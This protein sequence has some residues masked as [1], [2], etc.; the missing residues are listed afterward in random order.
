MWGFLNLSVNSCIQWQMPH[1]C[2]V[3][4]H[5]HPLP[6][7]HLLFPSRCVLVRPCVVL[8]Q[9]ISLPSWDTFRSFL[10][11]A[12]SLRPKDPHPARQC[13]K[14]S[15]CCFFSRGAKVCIG[16]RGRLSSLPHSCFYGLASIVHIV[17]IETCRRE[18]IM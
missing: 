7:L 5:V 12:C 3:Y 4:V 13:T 6:S 14:P 16:G 18:G 8:P 11:A 17:C 10:S 15:G 2:A 1:R 9:P